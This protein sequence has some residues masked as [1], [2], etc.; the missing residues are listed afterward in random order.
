MTRFR[1][2]SPPSTGSKTTPLLHVLVGL[3]QLG[4]TP[5]Y[6]QVAIPELGSIEGLKIRSGGRCY[7]NDKIQLEH[8][9]SLEVSSPVLT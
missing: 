2:G 3:N 8:A 1:T 6:A 7:P 5:Q 4:D 9:R